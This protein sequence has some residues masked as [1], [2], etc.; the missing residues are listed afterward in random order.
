VGEPIEV[1]QVA[2]RLNRSPAAL[3]RAFQMGFTIPQ[4]VEASGWSFAQV[5]GSIEGI[6]RV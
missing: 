6:P 3:V 4:I 5:Y 2:M 1:L